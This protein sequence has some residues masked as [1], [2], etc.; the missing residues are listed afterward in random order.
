MFRKWRNQ[1]T[2]DISTQKKKKKKKKK[3]NEAGKTFQQNV[4]ASRICMC[5]TAS[6]I[7]GSVKSCI[8]R[9]VMPLHM[10]F[11]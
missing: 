8:T 3:K 11:K 1:K 10:I 2:L 9:Q 4:L 6:L 7:A 5:V